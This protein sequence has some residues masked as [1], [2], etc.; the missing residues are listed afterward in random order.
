MK[1][2]DHPQFFDVNFRFSDEF[3]QPITGN[4][5]YYISNYGRVLSLVNE[6]RIMKHELT[7]GYPHLPLGK[8]HRFVAHAFIPKVA[9]KEHINHINYD[10]QDNRVINLEWCTHAENMAHSKGRPRKKPQGNKLNEEKVSD[11]ILSKLTCNEL[12]ALYNVGVDTIRKI[13]R[14]ALWRYVL[15]EVER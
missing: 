12:S 10:R 5:P 15:P 7:Q 8:I 2:Y 9:G 3:F 4:E 6:G 13:K 11:I 14:G 1:H